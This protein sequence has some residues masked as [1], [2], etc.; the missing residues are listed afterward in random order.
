MRSRDALFSDPQLPMTRAAR[1]KR[2]SS[3]VIARPAPKKR[4]VPTNVQVRD[5][6]RGA[7]LITK[8]GAK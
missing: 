6:G 3:G 8:P 4:A 2:Q 5:L 1:A 7:T